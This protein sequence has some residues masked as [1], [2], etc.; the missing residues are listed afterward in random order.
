MNKKIVL[1]LL[2][3]IVFTSS[4]QAAGSPLTLKAAYELALKRS[5]DVAMTAEVI[6]EAEGHFYEALDIVMP[7]VNFVMTHVDQDA[8]QGGTSNESSNSNLTRRSTPQKRFTFSQ[9]LFSGFKEFASLQGTGSEKNQR[10]FEWQRAKELLFVDVAESFYALLEARREAEVLNAVHKALEDR[11]KELEGRV[12]L[13]RSRESEKETALSELKVNEADL[14]EAQDSEIISK[15]LLEFYIGREIH[16]ELL[17]EDIP[18]APQGLGYYLPMADLR[19]DVLAE[20]EAYALAETGV[21][22][23]QAGFLPTVKLD[24]NYYTQR[25]GTQS[26]IDWDVTL[27]MNVPVFDGTDT[28]GKVKVAAADREKERL[29]VSKKKRQAMLDI[30]NAYQRFHSSSLKAAALKE[31]MEALK[32]NYEIQTQ[33][34]RSN[35][36]NNLEVLDALRRYEDIEVKSSSADMEARKNYW[37]LKVAAGETL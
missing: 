7:K 26:G 22:A 31:A 13:G 9:P 12:K 1:V 23:A 33:E 21:V 37:K 19:S 36:V 15:D 10:R 3:G 32:K 28:I 2:L 14:I 20:K 6:H 30:Q 29:N 11:V 24:G 16:E 17:D 35:L 34:Y 25:V 4:S 27:T 18:N 8:P 5:E